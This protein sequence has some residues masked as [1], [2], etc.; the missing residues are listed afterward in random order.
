M[1]KRRLLALILLCL[2]IS[3]AALA[4]WDPSPSSERRFD[5]GTNGI[6][7]GHKW[8]TGRGVRTGEPV[9]PNEVIELKENLQSRPQQRKG[10]VSDYLDGMQRTFE[11]D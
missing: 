4:L 11:D 2:G 7:L 8:Y 3:I 10:P 5:R 1:L 6:W 9:T